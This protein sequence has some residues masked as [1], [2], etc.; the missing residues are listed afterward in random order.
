MTTAVDK[1]PA[2]T[3]LMAA[4]KGRPLIHSSY[5]IATDTNSICIVLRLTNLIRMWREYLPPY[6]S[7]FRYLIRCS[8]R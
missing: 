7:V 4:A 6:P 8:M 5:T 3:R 2:A 1:W